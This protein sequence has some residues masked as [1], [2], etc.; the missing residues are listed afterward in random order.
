MADGEV[1]EYSK[2]FPSNSH[3]ILSHLRE[4][5][6]IFE[7][8][9]SRKDHFRSYVDVDIC[10]SEDI[11]FTALEVSYNFLHQKKSALVELDLAC[12][13]ASINS[14]AW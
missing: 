5:Q 10:K 6:S 9:V 8:E 1:G 7:R 4:F 14:A 3:A 12:L 2:S 11:S 13:L